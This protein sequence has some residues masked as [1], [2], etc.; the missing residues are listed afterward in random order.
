MFALMVIQEMLFINTGT[1]A[2][3]SATGVCGK[4]TIPWRNIHL[5]GGHG[6]VLLPHRGAKGS[7]KGESVIF[8][9]TGIADS[10][11]C[12]FPNRPTDEG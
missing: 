7:H 8:A 11:E 9:D 10:M 6:A 1:N 12:T 4:N 3:N 5:L 2:T